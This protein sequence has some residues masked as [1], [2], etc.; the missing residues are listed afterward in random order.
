MEP[1]II[2]SLEQWYI[3]KKAIIQK[4]YKL[5]QFQYNWCEDTGFHSWFF[6]GDKNYEIITHN[7]EIQD[8]IIGS[9]LT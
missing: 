1:K 2:E 7:K 5:H 6:K 8:D 9:G 3:L 4:G